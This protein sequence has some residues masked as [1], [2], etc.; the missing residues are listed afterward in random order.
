MTPTDERDQ[1]FWSYADVLIFLGLAIPTLLASFLLARVALL[2]PGTTKPF[3][4]LLAQLVWY[5]LL[6]FALAA[7]FRLRYDRPVLPSLGWR[8]P[9][10]GEIACL[11]GGPLMAFAIG[12]LGV[13]LKTPVIKLPMFDQML[14]N[15]P[16]RVL[17]AA[18]VVV[19]GPLAEELVFRGF[20][21]PLLERTIGVA[22][23]I[24]MVGL[25]FGGLHASE[26]QWSWRHVV[27]VSLVGCILG[28]VRHAARST[29]AS[30]LLHSTYNL[31]QLVAFFANSQ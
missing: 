28:W 13:A 26:Y 19:L 1:A 30:T 11:A 15:G 31:T 27:L 29:A 9:F 12:G 20:F 7:I 6:F 18:F 4:G 8:V 23:G 22:A 14:S 25:L 5:V 21:L 10:R 2:I 16:T 24:V 17:F 3:I